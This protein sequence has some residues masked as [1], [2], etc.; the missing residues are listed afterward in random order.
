M[1]LY[2][3]LRLLGSGVEGTLGVDTVVFINSKHN[4]DDSIQIKLDVNILF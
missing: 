1:V 4:A 2:A 3:G